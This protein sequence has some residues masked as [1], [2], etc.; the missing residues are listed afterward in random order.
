MKRHML[1]VITVSDEQTG[2][3]L[4]TAVTALA[5]GY[6]VIRGGVWFA[7]EPVEVNPRYLS[8]LSAVATG[9]L[10]DPHA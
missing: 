1:T 7:V 2:N 3:D 10:V 5:K 6:G 8:T 4:A 9:K